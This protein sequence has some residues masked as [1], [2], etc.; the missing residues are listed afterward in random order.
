MKNT[1]QNKKE[2]KIVLDT[3]VRNQEDLQKVLGLI[4][5]LNS[6]INGTITFHDKESIDWDALRKK[7]NEDG[8]SL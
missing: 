1:K 3:T 8:Q 2:V 7:V 6:E 4:D 5:K